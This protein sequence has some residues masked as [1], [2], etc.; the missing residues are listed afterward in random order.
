VLYI[1]EH[2]FKIE[3][4]WEKCSVSVEFALIHADF[5]GSSFTT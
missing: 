2:K 5:W 4:A 3:T 1:N